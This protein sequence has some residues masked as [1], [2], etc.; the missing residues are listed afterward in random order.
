MALIPPSPS[1]HWPPISCYSGNFEKWKVHPHE[2]APVIQ[3]ASID[4]SAKM[5]NSSRPPSRPLTPQLGQFCTQIA[6]FRIVR[7]FRFLSTKRDA[8][9]PLTSFQITRLIQLVGGENRCPLL[10]F[11]R[12]AVQSFP[13]LA[14]CLI[15]RCAVVAGLSDF[16][17]LS[18]GL[19]SARE[20]ERSR[21]KNPLG[22]PV[23][24]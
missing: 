2:L 24:N 10:R 12:R 17:R 8:V 22:G 23:D 18:I 9:N 19:S 13:P 5:E 1:I 6:F 14:F 20:K 11:P 15:E 4:P 3:S 16:S 7:I 21:E